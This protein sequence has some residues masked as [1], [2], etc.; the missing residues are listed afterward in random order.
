MF[1][2]RKQ[3]YAVASPSYTEDDYNYRTPTYSDEGTA[4]IYIVVQDRSLTNRND[5]NLYEATYVG[6][7]DRMD[8]DKNWLIDEDYVVISTLPH[9]DENI[10][11]LRG[12]SDGE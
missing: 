8:I 11:Y 12:F 7:T 3:V 9:R 6:Y 10:L 2:S 1:E 4:R 5:L